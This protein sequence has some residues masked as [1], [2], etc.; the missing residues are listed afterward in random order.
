[1]KFKHSNVVVLEIVA[2]GGK[3]G[4]MTAKLAVENILRI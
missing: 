1:V 4:E 2:K 3:K